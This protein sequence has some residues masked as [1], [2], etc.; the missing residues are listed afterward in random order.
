LQPVGA[1]V[2][3]GQSLFDGSDAH[4]E[5]HPNPALGLID[6]AVGSADT[7]VPRIW[8]RVAAGGPLGFGADTCVVGMGAWRAATTTDDIWARTRTS[9]ETEIRLIKAQLETLWAAS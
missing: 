8:I 1:G 2:F 3:R 7:R 4:V 5:I 6:F 9:H